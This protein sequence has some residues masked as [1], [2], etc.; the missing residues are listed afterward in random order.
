VEFANR[1]L[2][3]VDEQHKFGVNQ[4]ARVRKLGIDPHYLVMTATPIPRTIA[5][6]VFGDLDT[7][8]I[9]QLPPGRQP[10][11]TRWHPP[12][13]R[14]RIHERCRELLTEGRQGFVVCPLVA[15]SEG[16]D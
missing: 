3:V 10:V 8:T 6:A 13:Q 11:K 16:L 2:V 4:R 5:L 7:S 14:D 12:S 15:E 9:R 1:G